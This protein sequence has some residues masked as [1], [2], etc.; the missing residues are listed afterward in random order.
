VCLLKSRGK[1]FFTFSIFIFIDTG[2][3]HWNKNDGSLR[4]LDI[5]VSNSC[6]KIFLCHF[7]GVRNWMPQPSTL[8][9]VPL[10]FITIVEIERVPNCSVFLPSKGLSFLLLRTMSAVVKGPTIP[11][12]EK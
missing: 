6:N 2:K 12:H 1:K 10:Y 11:D 9:N 5:P 3:L 8:M 4:E 7:I